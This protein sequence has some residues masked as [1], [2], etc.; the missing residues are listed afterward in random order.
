MEIVL[1]IVGP[2]I[3]AIGVICIFAFSR[4][5]RARKDD[6]LNRRDF[7]ARSTYTWGIIMCTLDALLLS[8]LIA[9]NIE[10]P[11][12]V[13]VTVVL[14]GVALIFAY[15]ILQAFREKVRVIEGNE[16][17]YTPTLGKKRKYTLEQIERVERKKTGIYVFADGK[18]VFSLD[19][20][21]IGTTM[22][23]EIY[24]SK[25]SIND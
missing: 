23:L 16:I 1:S 2:I 7:V 5:E 12:N 25:R 14:C 13:G 4:K 21:G 17:I 10:K 9:G 24:K 6:N 11:F 22:F 18:K 20:S 19:P 15:G 8:V 3:I